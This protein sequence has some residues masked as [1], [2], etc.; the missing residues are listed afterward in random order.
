FF[1]IADAGDLN[2]VAGMKQGL[3]VDLRPFFVLDAKHHRTEPSRDRDD[4]EFD[5]GLDLF[6]SITSR[7]KLSVSINTDFAETEVDDRQVNLTRFPLFFPER[8]DFFLEDSGVFV[9]AN[10]NAVIPFFSRR[11]G[12]DSANGEVPLTAAAKF[13]A[14]TDEFSVGVLNVQTDDAGNL[15]GQNLSVGRFSANILE[16]SDIGVIWTHGDPTSDR[17]ADTY[18]LDLNLRT[19]E[20]LGDRN[21]RFNAYAVRSDNEAAAGEED[22]NDTAFA[23]SLAY[24]NDEISANISWTTVEERFDPS[25]G[26]VRRPGSKTY[27]GSFSYRPRQY[28]EIRRFIF[29]VEPQLVTDSG[30]NTQTVDFDTV[31]FGIEWESGDEFF[32]LASHRREVLDEDFAIADDVT[33]PAG[34]YGFG[35]AS[36]L[37]IASDRRPFAGSLELGFGDFF[38]G[39]RSSVEANLDVRRFDPLVLSL[40][41][42]YDDIDLE[43][44]SFDVHTARTRVEFQFTPEVTW[45]NVL[46][47]DNVTD[48]LGWNARLWWIPQPG[49]ELFLVANQG[50]EVTGG[51]FDPTASQYT[52]KLGTTL[53]F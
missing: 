27:E 24:P 36:L 1:S 51:D 26:F 38:D 29:E 22:G 30:N 45:S 31:P 33:I 32:V 48:A 17:R 20:F 11:I 40:E 47:Y 37:A 21:L 28:T 7:S 10:D 9:F 39:T 52:F 16:Q 43:G 25:L 12:L 3:G 23:M 19:T 15:D 44:G 6:Y 53:R 34:S 2:G 18:G 49:R 8:R 13:T 14:Q 35:R 4:F 41:Y 5:A 50:W 42:E 46:Q